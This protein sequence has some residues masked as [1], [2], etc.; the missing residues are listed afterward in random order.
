MKLF[1]KACVF[2]L[3]CSA[4]Y[5]PSVSAQQRPNV[6]PVMKKAPEP[7]LPDQKEFIKAFYRE[8]KKKSRPRF[9]LFWNREFSDEVVTYYID[10]VAA[11][12]SAYASASHNPYTGRTTANVSPGTTEVTSGTRRLNKDQARE[13]LRELLNMK[14]ES[15]FK[16]TMIRGGTRVI[17]R[18]MAIRTTGAD[19][20]SNEEVNTHS[21]ETKAMVGKA[22]L[23][24]EILLTPSMETESGF[25][26]QM[27]VIEI[28]TGENIASLFTDGMPPVINR[29]EFIATNRGFERH[30]FL[31]GFSD[32]AVGRQLAI[33]TMKE[34][35]SYWQMI[36]EMEG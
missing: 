13:N 30:T 28:E 18:E 15:S 7:K 36:A 17:N 9:I 27:N 20:A 22:D 14:L 26:F 24:I 5:V 2:A 32:E 1:M 34:L 31:E 25:A 21:L 16:K 35:T 8:N 4:F 10:Y 29:Q 11:S 6:P 12:S 19:A 33:E 3:A 23:M